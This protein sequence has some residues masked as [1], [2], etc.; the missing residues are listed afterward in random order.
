MTMHVEIPSLR[1]RITDIVMDS[2]QC[3]ENL[4]Q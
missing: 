3:Q 4:T 1:S 2:G